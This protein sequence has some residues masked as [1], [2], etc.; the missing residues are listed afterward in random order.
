MNLAFIL[1][2]R[3]YRIIDLRSMPLR[4]FVKNS[5]ADEANLSFLS[6]FL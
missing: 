6:R 2:G 5:G 4:T 1:L 3:P